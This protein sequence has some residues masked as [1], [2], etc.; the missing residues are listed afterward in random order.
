MKETNDAP[1]LN[2][3]FVSEEEEALRVL[4][5]DG[6]TVER[7]VNDRVR[8]VLSHDAWRRLFNLDSSFQ[9]ADVDW[10]PLGKDKVYVRFVRHVEK[11]S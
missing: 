8:I 4:A 7:E 9:P 1:N 6:V 10:K 3:I 5:N 11:T 2:K